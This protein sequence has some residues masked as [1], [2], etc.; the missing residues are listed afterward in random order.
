MAIALPVV[1]LI[2]KICIR[3]SM[4]CKSN[5]CSKINSIFSWAL[6]WNLCARLFLLCLIEILIAA[7][8][9]LKLSSDL[10]SRVQTRDKVAMFAT[11]LCIMEIGFFM[12]YVF[13][14]SGLKNADLINA[15]K[16]MDVEKLE[17]QKDAKIQY[18]DEEADLPTI[19]IEGQREKDKARILK[20]RQEL[21]DYKEDL[22]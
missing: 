21:K 11:Y 17:K 12:L 16:A 22:E 13:Y 20:Y 1:L 6:I 14:H 10:K 7:F 5:F 8:L 15:K 2:L 19:K 9:G 18:Q 3:L 4:V